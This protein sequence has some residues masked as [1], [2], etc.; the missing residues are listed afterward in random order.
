M[1][2]RAAGGCLSA[3]DPEVAMFQD[4]PVSAE[5]QQRHF[6]Q[7][8]G[9][10]IGQ[11]CLGA[12]GHSSLIAVDN[13]RAKPALGRLFFREHAGQV[14]R[15]GLA[16]RMLLLERLLGIQRC[17]GGRIM[18]A[19]AALPHICPPLGGLSRVH[20]AGLGT[21]RTGTA[22]GEPQPTAPMEPVLTAAMRQPTTKPAT[23]SK[24]GEPD[25][26]PYPAERLMPHS[27]PRP[28][29]A[30]IYTV[31]LPSPYRAHAR[32]PNRSRDTVQVMPEV[33]RS[34]APGR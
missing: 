23:R 2:A 9:A 13:R 26:P 31:H 22:I 27:P 16:E 6:G 29:R 30:A 12:P 19:P 8:L 11:P 4:E 25:E 18:L 21:R 24:T 17:D 10:A 3:L 7:V 33:A 14:T 28:G 32:G 15:L 5:A 20:A 34:G 1:G